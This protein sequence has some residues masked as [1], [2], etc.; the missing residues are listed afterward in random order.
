ML[1]AMLNRAT[2]CVA[3]RTDVPYGKRI[4]RLFGQRP[5]QRVV[6]ATTMIKHRKE[7]KTHILLALV[8]LA[9]GFVLPMFAQDKADP[10][11]AQQ[12]HAVIAK[13]NEAFNKHD[14]A[15]VAALYTEDAVLQTYHGTFHGRQS[16]EKMFADWSFKRWNKH[17]W[18]TG[19][20][21]MITVGNEVRTTGSWSCDLG[22]GGSDSGFCSW[23][24]VH[25]GDTLKIR[26]EILTSDNWMS[27]NPG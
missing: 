3:D 19:M 10:K 2:T 21:R 15:A 20:T 14:P 23:V 22:G 27:G 18:A 17:N 1:P 8:G 26:K 12:V 5:Q 11:M 13:F 4:T 16:I 9:T 7:M 6:S 25:E 24:L